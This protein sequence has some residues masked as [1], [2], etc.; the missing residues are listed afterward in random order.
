M[1]TRLCAGAALVVAVVFAQSA[2]RPKFEVASVKL[3]AEQRVMSVRSLPGGR[4]A[5]NAPV[6]LLIMYAYGFQLSEVAGGPDWINADRYEIDAKAEDNA[7][8]ARLMP[9][10]QSLL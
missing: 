3:S 5:A 9:M 8:R 6:K 7:S 1:Y 10:L 4:V 2:E